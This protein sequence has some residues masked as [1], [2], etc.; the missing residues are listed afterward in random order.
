MSDSLDA[1]RAEDQIRDAT[2]VDSADALKELVTR[3]IDEPLYGIDT[4]FHR[5]RT[6][7]AKLALLQVAWSG[8]IALIDPLRVDVEP[9]GEVMRGPALAILHAADQDLEVLERACGCVPDRLFD[10]QIAAG[11]LGQSTPSLL[12]IVERFLGRKL[13][14]GD[15][16]TDWTRRPLTTAQLRYGASDV[17]HLLDLYDVIKGRL[18]ARNRYEWALE[19]CTIMLER[20]RQPAVPEQL[21]WK[22]RQARQLRNQE[23][24]IAQELCAWRERRA[25]SNDQPVRFLI[26]DLAIASI[27]HRPPRSRAEL[28][29]VRSI[30]SRHLGGGAADEIL[31]A[32]ARG[33]NLAQSEL[34]LP[35]GPQGES[36]AKPAIA[37]A[38]AWI[39][40]RANQLDIDTAIL[41]T[42]ADIVAFFQDPPAGRLQTSWRN[43]LI[44]EPIRRLFAGDVAI[45]LEGSSLV[46]EERS[47]VPFSLD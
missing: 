44:G 31:A 36:I 33:R 15:Q 46:L 17:A 9:F 21:W 13:E 34:H 8:G 37:I 14:K 22:L 23:R 42:R 18:E 40:E 10:T 3:L 24:A 29:Q 41:A 5:E 45:V 43:K 28:E 47:R 32:I 6:Y 12:N 38:A 35:P 27:V 26:S 7:Y 25:R 19:E 1:R 39:S 20:S 2:L 30:E 16:L 11:F 4:E